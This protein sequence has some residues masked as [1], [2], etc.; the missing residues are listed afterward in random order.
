MVQYKMYTYIY[1]NILIQNHEYLLWGWRHLL[2]ETLNT[3]VRVP[4]ATWA[5][6]GAKTMRDWLMGNCW[7]VINSIASSLAAWYTWHH[8]RSWKPSK[9]MLASLITHKKNKECCRCSN[10]SNFL[11][12]GPQWPML[13]SCIMS[14]L[15]LRDWLCHWLYSTPLSS[16][17]C[18]EWHGW[19]AEETSSPHLAIRASPQLSLPSSA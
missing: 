14:T 13:M 7:K 12:S 6:M 9:M 2:L 15:F 10:T 1:N 4:H 5:H 3:P 19:L 16:S 18:P 11:I 17:A 8:S